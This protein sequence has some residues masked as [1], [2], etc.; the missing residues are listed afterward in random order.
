MVDQDPA[1]EPDNGAVQHTADELAAAGLQDTEPSQDLCSLQPLTS[2]C[3]VFWDRQSARDPDATV[4]SSCR[5]QV[6][7]PAS[8]VQH[9]CIIHHAAML[10]CASSVFMSITRDRDAAEC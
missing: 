3:G 10:Q 4:C 5:S 6:D 8:E 1:P 2:R 7:H 9:G